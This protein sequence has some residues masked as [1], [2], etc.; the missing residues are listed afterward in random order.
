MKAK[1]RQAVLDKR[2]ENL[3]NIAQE[4]QSAGIQHYRAHPRDLKP[5]MYQKDHPRQVQSI[6]NQLL[7]GVVPRLFESYTEMMLVKE[8]H[9]YRC[10]FCEREQRADTHHDAAMH[11]IFDCPA[12]EGAREKL[13][14]A[15]NTLEPSRSPV[16]VMGNNDA[17]VDFAKRVFFGIEPKDLGR[18]SNEARGKEERAN[19]GERRA[20]CGEEAEAGAAEDGDEDSNEDSYNAPYE[21]LVAVGELESDWDDSDAYS[22]SATE[23]S[24]T[25]EHAWL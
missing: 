22:G 17:L 7:A 15:C 24:R 18:G 5:G 11:L 19:G 9:R 12:C 25:Y 1:I 23:F 2:E 10:K 14:R 3:R 21:F 20:D 16:L 6:V 13:A 4:T 8:T